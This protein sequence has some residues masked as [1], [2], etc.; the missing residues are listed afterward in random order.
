MN[1]DPLCPFFYDHTGRE[2]V[3]QTGNRCVYCDLISCVR[4]D[5]R[6]KTFDADWSEMG[7]LAAVRLFRGQAYAA[8]LRDAAEAVKAYADER[9]VLTKH[10]NASE[11]ITAALRVAAKRIE[12]LGGEQ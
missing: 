3:R 9:L 4:E 8:A 1:H 6:Q 7:Q 11:D 2:L 10:P 12:A 5:E